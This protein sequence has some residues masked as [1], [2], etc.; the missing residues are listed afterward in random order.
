MIIKRK[1]KQC[2]G[3]GITE[4]Y[5]CQSCDGIGFIEFIA[6][7]R[8]PWKYERKINRPCFLWKPVSAKYMTQRF[9]KA[10]MQS[11]D[12]GQ[13]ITKGFFLF[14]RSDVIRRPPKRI[15]KLPLIDCAEGL[16]DEKENG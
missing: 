11:I 3:T 14:R 6:K 15:A 1:C 12:S 13:I 7:D 16:E 8:A 4:S 5:E 10:E 9:T 2:I